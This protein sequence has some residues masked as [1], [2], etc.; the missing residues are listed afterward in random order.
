MVQWWTMAKKEVHEEDA[1]NRND[2][3][4]LPYTS[5]PWWRIRENI[6]V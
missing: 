6:T 4:R 3:G 2:W 1:M 5:D